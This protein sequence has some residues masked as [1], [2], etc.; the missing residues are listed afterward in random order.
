MT[1]PTPGGVPTPPVPGVPM[2]PGTLTAGPS[3]EQ[4]VNWAE[5]MKQAGEQLQPVPKGSY[6]CYVDTCEATQTSNGKLMYKVKL[7][8]SGG[9]HNGRPLWNNITLTTD[10]PN[11]LAMFFRNMDAFGLA[12]DYFATNPAPEAVAD[13]L[14]GRPVR[15]VVNHRTWQGSIRENVD[16][17]IKPTGVAAIAGM[18]VPGGAVV[19]T[20]GPSAPV[21]GPPVPSAPVAPAPAVSPP[22]P[23]TAPPPAAAPAPPA[24]APPAPEP[25]PPAQPAV[26]LDAYRAAG[27][28]DEQLIAAGHMAAPEPPPAPPTPEPAPPA[29]APEP[30]AAEVPP[31]PDVPPPAP[32][33][34][35]P[36]GPPAPP[37]VPF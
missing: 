26:D 25:E 34:P 24:A 20:P 16:K 17:L 9:P 19:P 31:A 27:W 37:P 1:I 12:M 15:V 3:P 4:G 32:P 2:P 6:D 29:P 30:P 14:I 23:A 10:N 33:A 36:A 28:T 35:A 11:A 8:I 22:Q 21:S 18:P 5:L 7:K 13:A